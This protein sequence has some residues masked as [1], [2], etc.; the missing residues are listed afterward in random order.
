MAIILYPQLVSELN[1]QSPLMSGVPK[2]TWRQ[3]RAEVSTGDLSDQYLTR[4]FDLARYAVPRIDDIVFWGDSLTR[5]SNFPYAS[6]PNEASSK[7]AAEYPG[8]ACFNKGGPGQTSDQI[9]ARIT[10]DAGVS[11]NAIQVFWLG[12]NDA[13][14]AIDP[15]TVMP[16]VASAVAAITSD[17]PRYVVLSVING[18]YSTEFVG[19]PKHT[20][21]IALNSA[22]ATEYAGNY[23][24]IRQAL[25]DAGDPVADAVDIA[26]DTVPGS[27]RSDNIHLNSAGTDVVAA[28]LKAFFDAKGWLA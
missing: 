25:I 1:V 15:G 28:Q 5:N 22:L 9:M 16:N 8:H 4:S 27:L 19:Q 24:D 6:M 26:N 23:I 14:W 13:S 20:L 3:A 21:L 7:I 2:V 18:N 17:V 11:M 10:A 12:R